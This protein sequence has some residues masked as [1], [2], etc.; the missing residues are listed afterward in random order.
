MSQQGK[1]N[2]RYVLFIY[3]LFMKYLLNTYF[4]FGTIISVKGSVMIIRQVVCS[5]KSYDQVNKYVSK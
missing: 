4:L 2:Y 1:T 5:F 3:T